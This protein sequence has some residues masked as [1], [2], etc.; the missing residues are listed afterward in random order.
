M[1]LKSAALYYDSFYR[2]VKNYQEEAQKVATIIKEL[3]PTARRI[4]D[5]ACGTG[6]HAS[7]LCNEYGYSVDGIDLN[8]NLLTIANTKIPSGDFFVA[9]MTNFSLE[10]TYDIII[11]LFSSIGYVQTIDNMLQTFKHFKEHL[12]EDGVVIVE[13]WFTPDTWSAGRFFLKTYEDEEVKLARMGH[14]RIEG[15][16]SFLDF[17]YLIATSEGIRRESETHELA[18]FTTEETMLCFEKSGFRVS[19]EP[20]GLCGRGLY[21]ARH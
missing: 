16:M 20:I 4:L 17:E 10:K 11:C 6:E 1:F 9:D 7:Y 2:T 3:N 21:V 8:E 18:L 5:V 19:Y 14:R 13:P 15:N 12:C